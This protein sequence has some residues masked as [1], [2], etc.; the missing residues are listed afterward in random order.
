MPLL[1]IGLSH[2]T[3]PLDMRERLAIGSQDYPGKLRELLALEG[4]GE[5]VI[6]STCNRTEVYTA[7]GRENRERPLA[8]LAG[9]GGIETHRSAELFYSK[10]GEDAVRHLFRVACGLDSMVLGEPQIMGQ[11][12]QAWQ[13][14]RDAGGAGKLTDRLFQRAFSISKEVR[15]ETGINDHPVSVA[16]IASVLA[17]QIFGDLS[18]K[19]VLMVGAGEMI[20][21]CGQHFHQHGVG[22]LMIANRTLERAREVGEPFGAEAMTLDALPERLHEADIVICCTAANEPVLRKPVI[23]KAIRK[24]RRAPMFM[25]DLGVPRDIEPGV[26]KLQD[27]YLYSIDDLRQVADEGLSKRQ[28]AANAAVARIE[29]AVTEYLRWMHGARAAEGL[30]RLRESAELSGAQLAERALHQLEAGND[31]A[32]VIKRLS[33]TLTHRIL[34]GPSTRLREA[35][36]LQHDE[37]LKAADWLF[38]DGVSSLAADPDDEG[39]QAPA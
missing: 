27:I 29:T 35:A 5:A 16:Y 31:P 34:H 21:L 14:S 12:K 6:L 28:E 2:H 25:V 26:A 17:R 36:E 33:N 20:T 13:A 19:T 9:H 8:W 32:D 24:R 30:R 3:A 37:I 11:L 4:V 22:R 15:S 10:Y 23:E 39:P 18:Q 1:A 38:D 7:V